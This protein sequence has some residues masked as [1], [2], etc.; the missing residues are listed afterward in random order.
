MDP[1]YL[2]ATLL[3]VPLSVA[4]DNPAPALPTPGAF[5]SV[6]IG[7]GNPDGSIW[8]RGE[9]YKV[10]LD[11][12]GAHFQ[13]LLGPKAPR[14]FPLSLRLAAVRSGE[15]H[16]TLARQQPVQ[17]GDR[18]VEVACGPVTERW[19]F[20]PDHAEQ[21]FVLVESPG[22]G[23]LV[24][25]LEI[26][27][28]LVPTAAGATELTFS[29][30]NGLGGVFCRDA[31]A[32][33]ATGRRL[34][35]PFG[36]TN[37]HLQL[38]VPAE[39]VATATF[40][41]VVDPVLS[42]FAIDT[43][44]SDMRNPRV[45]YEP[46]NDVWLV[47]QEEQLSATDSDIQCRRYSGNTSAP[48]L[49]D[50]VYAANTPAITR[51]PD[52]G[53]LG[54]LQRFQIAWCITTGVGT[55]GAF[56]YRQRNA[57]DQTQGS[58]FGFGAGFGSDPGT[59]PRIGGCLAGNRWL[60]VGFKQ[61]ATAGQVAVA[62]MGTDSQNFGNAV[63]Y[64]GLGTVA[65]DVSTLRD[66]NDHW[67]VVWA[68]CPTPTTAPCP[69]L[70]IAMVA[71]GGT[72]P[73]VMQP[74]ISLGMGT[75][76]AQPTI[77]GWGGQ[78]LAA[79]DLPVGIFSRIGCR[80]IGPVGGVFQPLGAAVD[81]SQLVGNVPTSHDQSAPSLSF[82]G[83]RFVCAYLDDDDIAI[84]PFA[85][86]LL[87]DANGIEANESHRALPHTATQVTSALASAST[88]PQA[89]ATRGHHGIVW[90]QPG[91]TNSDTVGAFVDA[92]TNGSTTSVAQTGC[93]TP[94]EPT[95]TLIGTPAL[96][97]TNT[98]VVGNVTGLP[99]VLVGSSQIA[100]LPGCGTCQTGIQLP[101]PFSFLTS[102][103]SIT[104]PTD[105][106]FRTSTWS[107][108]GLDLLHLGGCPDPVFGAAFAVTDTITV[109]VL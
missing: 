33:D 53:L 75:F 17:A 54:S 52:V 12:K 59:Y 23:E 86:T 89:N 102:S 101:V 8:V 31:A 78:L 107:V 104:W 56:E 60:L 88:P 38:R 19:D 82:D 37:G 62:I 69:G 6:Y 47:V 109:R 105:A 39:F 10:G 72:A 90:A 41:L 18:R 15:R 92:R 34:C 63:V 26:E 61:F 5:H 83:V 76:V 51:N 98:F 22:T 24:V 81:L 49:L 27:T 108:Q 99:F 1:K 13:P 100:A 64:S 11:A 29:A 55:N 45:E 57:N 93:G 46:T 30:P 66:A 70:P 42:T 32:I 36:Y 28:D 73:I 58:V 40:P 91:A 44:I 35:L 97:R 94:A 21:S 50:T 95:L 25:D 106:A 103:L 77:A 20:A 71:V 2:L 67:G 68:N 14:D 9:R 43:T 65:G 7:G 80:A 96:G 48:V 3:L 16:L 4:Q 85:S 79:W 87:V 84:H 74:A